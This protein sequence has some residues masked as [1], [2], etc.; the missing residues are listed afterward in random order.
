MIILH[1]I[2]KNK[3]NLIKSDEQYG[4]EQLDA[5]GFIHCSPIEYFWRV[6]PNFISVKEDLVLLCIDTKKVVPAIKWED[7]DDCGREYPHVYGMLN[8]DAVIDVV[9]F[10]RNESSHFIMSSELSLYQYEGLDEE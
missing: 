1:C 9:P 4:K 2:S 6:A 10:N 7:G 5:F 3:W 8:L